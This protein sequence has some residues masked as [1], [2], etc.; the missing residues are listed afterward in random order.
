MRMQRADRDRSYRNGR[1]QSRGQESRILESVE[2]RFRQRL[3]GRLHRWLAQERWPD[4]VLGTGRGQS[5]EGYV[6]DR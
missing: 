4:D 3:V 2:A 1:E 6:G 5:R